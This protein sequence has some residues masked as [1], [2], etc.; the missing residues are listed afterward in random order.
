MLVH[1]TH[2]RVHRD[3]LLR[4]VIEPPIELDNQ[5]TAHA[6]AGAGGKIVVGKGHSAANVTRPRAAAA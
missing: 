4:Y 2:A 1:A 3:K 5:M 6:A